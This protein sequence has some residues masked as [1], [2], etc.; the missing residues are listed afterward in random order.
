MDVNKHITVG[1][2][3]QLSCYQEFSRCNTKGIHHME[4]T[5]NAREGIHFGVQTEGRHHEKSNIGAPVAPEK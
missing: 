2:V 5:K 4:V 1:K 3:V